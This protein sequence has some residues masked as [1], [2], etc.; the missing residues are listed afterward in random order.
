MWR[1]TPSSGQHCMTL[2][3]SHVVVAGVVVV[4]VV[5]VAPE[6]GPGIWLTTART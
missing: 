4:V 6:G 1:T 2:V 3:A 5:V